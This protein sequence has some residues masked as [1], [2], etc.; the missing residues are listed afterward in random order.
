MPLSFSRQKIAEAAKELADHLQ[1]VEHI[2]TLQVAQK[3]LADSIKVLG[4]RIRE[5]EIEMRALKAET[6]LQAVRETQSIINSVQGGLNQRIET[7]AVQVALIQPDVQQS[8]PRSQRRLQRKVTK[9]IDAP[10]G[11][12]ESSSL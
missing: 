1:V 12:K 10:S 9:L 2:K 5:I 11:E 7:L 3:E 4:D 6:V 8:P